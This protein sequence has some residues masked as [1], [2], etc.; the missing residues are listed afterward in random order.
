MKRI[1]TMIAIVLTGTGWAV[2]KTATDGGIEWS[3]EEVGS[4]EARIYAADMTSAIPPDTAG[5]ITIPSKLDGRN[6]TSIG[7]WAFY[8]CDKLRIVNVPVGVTEIKDKAFYGCSIESV[9]TPSTITSIG[10]AAFALCNSLRTAQV[11]GT[12]LTVLA[13]ARLRSRRPAA[14]P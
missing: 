4:T 11:T 5:E 8:G 9:W 13:M 12:S 14:L 1:L 6:V 2:I 10:E 3:Y 7:S